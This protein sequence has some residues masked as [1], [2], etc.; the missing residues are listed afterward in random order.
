MSTTAATPAKSTHDEHGSLV[1]P[2]DR[3]YVIIALILA[4]ITAVEI[5]L[6][7]VEDSFGDATAPLLIAGSLLKFFIVVAYFMHLKFDN[8][9]L[10]RMFVSAIVLSLAIYIA[11]LTSMGAI[12]G[13]PSAPRPEPEP[14]PFVQG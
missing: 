14:L 2:S 10:R 12:F 9:F 6:Y 4:A 5:A 1:H 13:R 8:P 3:K 7:Y 11:L